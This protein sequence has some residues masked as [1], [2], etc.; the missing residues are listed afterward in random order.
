MIRRNINGWGWGEIRNNR[1]E[2]K[3]SFSLI[4]LK[5]NKVMPRQVQSSDFFWESKHFTE[6]VCS[7]RLNEQHN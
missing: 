6:K 7:S 5:L 4:E 3:F 1:K 2:N